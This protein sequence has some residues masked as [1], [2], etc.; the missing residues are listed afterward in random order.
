MTPPQE[1]IRRSQPPP[2][3]RGAELERYRQYLTVLAGVQVGPGMRGRVDLSGVVQQTF[4]EAHQKLDQF[5]GDDGGD[6]N[7]AMAAWLRRILANN[8]ADALRGARRDKRDVGRERS[9]EQELEQSSVRLGAILADVNQ[10][11]PSQGA[12][13][14]DRAVLLAA[15]LA[16]LPEAQ[17]EVVLLRHWH[18]WPLARVAEHLGRT[19]AAVVGLLHRGLK[20][21]REEL[22][23]RRRKGEL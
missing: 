23:E 19:P 1:P 17:R 9:L 14:A 10:P 4:L 6:G 12:Q 7:A 3:G 15:A 2:S 13:R 21:L 8:L 18:G 22:A 16:T 20:S 11:S 5:R